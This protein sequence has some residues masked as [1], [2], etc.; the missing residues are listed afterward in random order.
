MSLPTLVIAGAQ[1]CGTTT[2][3]A[4]VRSHPQVFMARP[5]ELHFFDR[6]FER[7]LNWYAEQFTPRAGQLHAGEAT[8]RYLYDE[9]ARHRM[10]ECLPEA[11]IVLILRDPAQRAYSHFWHASNRGFESETF[12]RA[13]LLENTRTASSSWDDRARYSYVG[14]GRYIEQISDLSRIYDRRQMHVMLLEDLVTDQT[15][16]LKALFSFLGVRIRPAATIKERWERRYRWQDAQ[17][18]Q[19]EPIAYPP[20]APETRRQLV[21]HYRSYNERL[22]TWLERDLSAWN[23][24]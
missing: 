4:L 5:K 8:P 20:M 14:R 6:H 18:G 23:E 16:A 10:M 17:E 15:A 2:L 13:V 3:S 24:V 22:S 19:A 9:S 11:L 1:K 21:E 7:G 12:E